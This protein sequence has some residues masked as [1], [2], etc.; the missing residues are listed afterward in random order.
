M[1][2]FKV[3]LLAKNPVDERVSQPV[4]VIVDTGSELTW[5]PRNLLESIGIR[6][7][8]KLSFAT[9]T[10][11]VIE[12]EVGYAILRAEGFETIDEVVFAQPGDMSLLGVRTVEGFG[13]LVD[14]IAH[15]LVAISTRL[16]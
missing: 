5:M 10:Q 4:E 9:A 1:S 2:M 6:P 16:V 11:Q 3:S 13:V 14:N 8:R 7:E 12:R 15:R